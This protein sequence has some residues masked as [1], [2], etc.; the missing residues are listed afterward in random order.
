MNE[1]IPKR[2][3]YTSFSVFKMAELVFEISAPLLECS[4]SSEDRLEECQRH[5]Y[6]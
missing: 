3:M 6:E 4:K 2:Y 1:I 5:I